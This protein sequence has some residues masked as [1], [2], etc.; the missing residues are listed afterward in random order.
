M[1]AL[2]TDATTK[3][4]V[5]AAIHNVIDL[6]G[7]CRDLRNR[8][9]AHRDLAL[10]LDDAAVPLSLGSRADMKAVLQAITA[11]LNVVE[12]HYKDSQSIFDIPIQGHDSLA[13]LR[14]LDD[15]KGC[16]RSDA[17]AS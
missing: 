14:A 12:H 1:P 6:S 11:V 3:A 7:F 15:G 8:H 9:I 10:A 4:A 5:E 17:N 13:L 2:I 16:K